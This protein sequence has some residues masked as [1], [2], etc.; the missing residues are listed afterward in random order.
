M[1]HSVEPISLVDDLYVAVR[2]LLPQVS[3]GMSDHALPV[4]GQDVRSVSFHRALEYNVSGLI[5]FKDDIAVPQS[6][7]T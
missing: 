3:F 2:V 5:E 4:A 6:F 7:P 1:T